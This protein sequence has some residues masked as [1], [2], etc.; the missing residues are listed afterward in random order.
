MKRALV[1]A[2]VVIS[3][4]AAFAQ[5]RKCFVQ[6]AADSITQRCRRRQRAGRHANSDS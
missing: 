2:L 1:A 5:R 4:G 3:T 6:T